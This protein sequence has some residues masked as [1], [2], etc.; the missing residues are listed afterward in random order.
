MTYYRVDKRPFSVGD[1][2]TSS[3]EYYEKFIGVT[4]DVEDT[5]ESR[6]PKTKQ[7]RTEC[8]FVFDDEVC[9]RKH[10][11]KMKD[12]KLYRVSIDEACI[13][14]RGDMAL[15]DTMKQLGETEKDMTAV[16][17][18]YWRGESGTKPEFEIMVPMAVVTEVI[19]TSDEERQD[20]LYT[21]L[22][23]KR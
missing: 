23:I 3:K 16:A 21:R 17:D 8:L 11:S 5:L 18:A 1:E 13:S 12:G 10:W 22:G 7:Q 2:I 4:K 20:H 9:A 14:H 15:M 6:R 19:S